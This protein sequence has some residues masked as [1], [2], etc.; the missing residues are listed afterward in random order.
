[1]RNLIIIS[2]LFLTFNL[3]SDTYL[4]FGFT[5]NKDTYLVNTSLNTDVV[6]EGLGSLHFKLDGL[7]GK[8]NSEKTVEKVTVTFNLKKSFTDRTYGYFESTGTYDGISDIDYRLIAGP[9]YGMYFIKRE[10]TTLTFEFGSSWLWEDNDSYLV[11]RLASDFKQRLSDNT[12]LGLSTR[13]YPKVTESSNILVES[14]L[15]LETAI[16]TRTS[17]NISIKDTYDS[18]RER[19]TIYS[20]SLRLL[21]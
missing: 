1:M 15:K 11:Y 18:N 13:I 20:S 21:L 9:G 14:E 6:R 3:Y 8:S 10:N 4:L 17:L 19:D 12:V 5:R 2:L 16:S 7:Y